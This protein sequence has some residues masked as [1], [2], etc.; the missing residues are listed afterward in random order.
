M[1]K[2]RISIWHFLLVL[3]IAVVIA[4]VVRVFFVEPTLVR[5]ASMVPTLHDHDRLLISKVSEPKRFDVVVFR[6]DNDHSLVKRVIGLPGEK[7]EYKE[8]AL[9]IDDKRYE[10]PYLETNKKALTDNGPLTNTFQLEDTEMGRATVPEGHFFVM[11]DNRR[12]S[13]DSRKIG[14]IPAEN[15]VGVSK[16]IFF[17]FHDFQ[18]MSE[19]YNT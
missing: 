4:L 1:E 3:L 14:A 18:W 10:E 6:T 15:V 12:L 13:K 2:S 17:P 16:L 8:D 5:G 9:Y 19:E 7:I 11:G